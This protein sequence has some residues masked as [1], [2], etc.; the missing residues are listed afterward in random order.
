M[1]LPMTRL[2]VAYHQWAPKTLLLGGNWLLRPARLWSSN[3]EMCSVTELGL[4]GVFFLIRFDRV[5]TSLEGDRVR[6][7]ET[8]FADDFKFAIFGFGNKGQ[9]EPGTYT[10]DCPQ[11]ISSRHALGR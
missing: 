1:F 10:E 9:F 7:I 2:S 11:R 3:Q 6:C 8:Q 5:Y 4:E